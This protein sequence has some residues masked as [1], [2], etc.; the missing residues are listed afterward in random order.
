MPASLCDKFY[1]KDVRMVNPQS[2]LSQET[3]RA[4]M[5]VMAAHIKEEDR[6]KFLYVLE[7]FSKN[8]PLV[9]ACKTLFE[10][11]FLSQASRI[12]LE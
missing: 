4:H 9:Y 10:G 2:E 1:Y 7:R 3:F 12:A 6:S 11:V 5:I 8:M